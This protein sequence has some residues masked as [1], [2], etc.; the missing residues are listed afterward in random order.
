MDSPL[1]F[2]ESIDL[3]GHI[4]KIPSTSGHEENVVAFLEE[5]LNTY[6]P[7]KV[8]RKDRNLIV[9]LGGHRTGP[10]ILLC[11]HIDTV[12]ALGTWTRDPFGAEKEDDKI[13]GLG[14][15]DAGASVVSLVA[16]ARLIDT[17]NVGRILLA[18]VAEEEVGSQ[19]FHAIEPGLPRYDA[20][21]FGE[22]TDLKAAT[23]MRGSMR[24]RIHSR[25][26]CCHAS[27]PWEGKNA[28]DQ[29]VID[30]QAIRAID[31]V[32]GSIWG[33]A[34]IE[35]TIV[36]GGKSPN[37][38][39]DLVETMLDI[40]TTP[41]KNNDWILGELKKTGAEIEI[42]SNRRRPIFNAP[43]SKIVQAYRKSFPDETDCIFNGNCD[44]AFSK[45]ASIILGPGDLKMAHVADEYTR[46]SDIKRAI[47]AYYNVINRFLSL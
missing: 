6:F 37:Q 47:A 30:V 31:L 19:G 25:G 46:P 14:S 29:M 11:S 21:I 40:R 7:K 16:A 20:A 4:I 44:M 28:I 10:T 5:R 24:A 42:L 34:T 12:E 43:D 15:N 27:M 45:A 35:P 3:L 1:V 41:D 26:R 17:P 8:T 18:L 36:G 32:D 22:P 33:G 23:S 38:I 13:Y 9:D 39:P 2:E